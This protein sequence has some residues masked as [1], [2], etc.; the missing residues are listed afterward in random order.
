MLSIYGISVKTRQKLQLTPFHACSPEMQRRYSPRRYKE[1]SKAKS[2]RDRKQNARMHARLSIRERAHGRCETHQTRKQSR[3]TTPPTLF[4]WAFLPISS[5]PYP[6]YSCL[7]H[8]PNSEPCM[9]FSFRLIPV[10]DR[11]SSRCAE[12]HLVA[13]Q[14]QP[15]WVN[16]SMTPDS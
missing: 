14:Y 1:L 9:I 12:S 13:C 4:P 16:Q 11:P 3:S 8:D 15:L 10:F 5:S 6:G 7:K 2:E